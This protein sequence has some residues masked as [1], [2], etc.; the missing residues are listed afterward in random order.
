M[1]KTRPSK[2]GHST[3]VSEPAKSNDQPEVTDQENPTDEEDDIHEENL[4][5]TRQE[6]ISL[7]NVLT[8]M[9]LQES[10]LNL[11]E[12]TQT[13]NIKIDSIG[14]ALTVISRELRDLKN[15][16]EFEN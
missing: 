13:L 10:N 16:T 9:E 15:Q 8:V 12:T 4:E 11:Q 14:E 1:A 3:L 7:N 5:K 2:N 6:Q